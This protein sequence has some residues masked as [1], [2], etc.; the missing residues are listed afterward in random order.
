MVAVRHPTTW[1][2][3]SATCAR[4]ALPAFR[5][6]DVREPDEFA[7]ELGNIPGSELVPLD[8]LDDTSRGWRRDDPLLIVCRSG[9]RAARACEQLVGAGFTRV[10]NLAGGML[11]WNQEEEPGR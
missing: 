9:N 6:I 5:V 4:Q 7:G 1:R 2:D 8:T 11:A 3:L 10:F